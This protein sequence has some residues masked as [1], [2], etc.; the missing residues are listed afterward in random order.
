MP[1]PPGPPGNSSDNGSGPATS[2]DPFPFIPRR[3]SCSN[4]PFARGL[5]FGIA[6][7]LGWVS[8]PP[9]RYT[10]LTEVEANVDYRKGVM[11]AIG[12]N[13]AALAAVIVDG[14]R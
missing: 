4:R 2:C 9:P 8:E 10:P 1:H 3:F 6:L 12:G 11:R 14:A 5:C 7:T 13:T